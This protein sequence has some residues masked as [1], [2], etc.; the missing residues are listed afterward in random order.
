[1]IRSAGGLDPELGEA[2]Q[3]REQGGRRGHRRR[4]GH[5]GTDAEAG[6]ELEA[7]QQEAEERDDHG[8]AGEAHGTA[9]GVLGGDGRGLRVEA[10]VQSLAVP[11]DDE[12]RVVDAHAE[13]DHR[14][15][16]G[17]EVGHHEDVGEQAGEGDAEAHAG[18]R[19]G[20]REAHGQHRAERDDEHDD[21]EGEADDLG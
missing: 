5:G 6:H 7:D 13:A 1:M 21:G 16:H 20:D 11:G 8:H 18:E 9:G 17:G 3:S 4:D 19:H 2:E 10:L 14:P 12:Q 15:D